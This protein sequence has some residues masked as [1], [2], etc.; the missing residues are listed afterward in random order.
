MRPTPRRL[1]NWYRDNAEAL[2]QRDVRDISRVR[3]LD[4]LPRLVR[5]AAT[6]TAQ[7]FNLSD[8]AGF[9]LRAQSAFNRGLR[10]ASRETLPAGTAP[11]LA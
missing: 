3:S 10:Y 6:Q 7:L 8:L 9:S 1:A 5:A 2:V 11:G 4:V